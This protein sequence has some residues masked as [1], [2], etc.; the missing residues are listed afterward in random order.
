[1]TRVFFATDIHGSEVCWRKFLNAPKFYGVDVLILGGDM[2][3]KALIPIVREGNRHEV[4]LQEHHYVLESEDEVVQMERRIAGHGYYPARMNRDEMA[5]LQ[6]NPE[7]V[8]RLFQERMHATLEHW[9]V[10]AEEK[11]SSQ[12]I[13]CYVCPGNDDRPETDEVIAKSRVVEPAE[14]RIVDIDGIEMISTGWSNPTPWE[15]YRE[16]SEDELGTRIERMTGELHDPA[17]AIFNLHCPPHGSKLDDA[18]AL[19]KELRPLHG[20]QLL[21]PVGST[22]VRDAITRHQPQLSL[23]GHIH[24]ARGV[25]R[26]GRTLAINPGSSY[27]TGILQGAVIEID[28]RRGVRTYA[29]VSG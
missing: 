16:C 23:H 8:D 26:L 3:G 11:F 21:R 14:G 6:A 4:V 9:M 29:L 27:E 13:R 15:T 17:R 2:T 28:A 19:D 7:M 20:G 1:V 24:E 12:P 18:P 10:L 5:A 22:A 25:A